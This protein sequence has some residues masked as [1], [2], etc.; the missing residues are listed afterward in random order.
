MNAILKSHCIEP[1]YLRD[2]DFDGFYASRKGSLL[3]LIE[4]AIGKKAL[5][6]ENGNGYDEEPEDDEN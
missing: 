5:S 3:D 6:G 2:D 1:K 4:K